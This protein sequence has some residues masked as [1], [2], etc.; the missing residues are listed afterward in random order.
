[1]TNPRE[2]ENEADD[3]D[4]EIGRPH[5]PREDEEKRGETESSGVARAEEE[6]HEI[7]DEDVLF[8]DQ[9]LADDGDLDIEP[10]DDRI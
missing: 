8:D 5:G 10:D 6:E 9:D 7:R 4:L 1:M 2:L 3:R